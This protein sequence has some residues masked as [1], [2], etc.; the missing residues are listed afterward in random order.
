MSHCLKLILCQRLVIIKV[1]KLRK[2]DGRL[3]LVILSIDEDPM[4]ANGYKY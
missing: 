3:V 1:G 4:A 2:F